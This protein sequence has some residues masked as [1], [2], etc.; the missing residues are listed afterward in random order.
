M[1][2][3]N[4]GFQ[5]TFCFVKSHVGGSPENHLADELAP[6]T[7]FTAPEVAPPTEKDIRALVRQKTHDAWKKQTSTGLEQGIRHY[8]V[9]N[10]P[11]KNSHLCPITGAYMDREAQVTLTRARTM[12]MSTAL[13]P[14]K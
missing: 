11:T 5:F 13:Q 9:G 10:M 7:I 12:Q 4:L 8:L 3:A 2:L 6:T 14:K 1:D